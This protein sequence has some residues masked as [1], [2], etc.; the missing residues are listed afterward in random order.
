[1]FAEEEARL[2]VAIREAQ[3]E[4]H[5]ALVET[6]QADDVAQ[7][8]DEVAHTL[9]TLDVDTMWKAATEVERRVL[10]D[11]FIAEILVLPDYL[12]VTVH[13]VPP[14][15]VRYQEVGL[16]ESGFGGVGGGL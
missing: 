11:E 9:R 1:L 6:K 7:R 12:D 13:G 5:D 4:S 10:I 2:T 8:F 15:H 16:K 14:L 3:R